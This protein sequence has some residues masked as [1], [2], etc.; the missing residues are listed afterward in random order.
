[1]NYCEECGAELTSLFCESCGT[2]SS[3]IPTS[4]SNDD[5]LAGLLANV[6][7]QGK[8]LTFTQVLTLTKSLERTYRIFSQLEKTDNF[9]IKKQDNEYAISLMPPTSVTKNSLASLAKKD[10]YHLIKLLLD[11]FIV[12]EEELNTFFQT[13]VHLREVKKVLGKYYE[14]KLEKGRYILRKMN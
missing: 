9:L 3:N 14:L 5:S 6:I 7:Q 11:L 12:S 2:I 1:M 4:L 10:Q 8:I 13:S